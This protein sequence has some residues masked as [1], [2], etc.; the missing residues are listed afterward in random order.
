MSSAEVYG[1]RDGKK[2]AC[3]FNVQTQ[4]KI[5]D[6]LFLYLFS[7]DPGTL[8]KIIHIHAVADFSRALRGS[9][10]IGNIARR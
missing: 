4:S 1:C 5:P 8:R 2:Q 10:S 9:C 7:L 6:G 3:N